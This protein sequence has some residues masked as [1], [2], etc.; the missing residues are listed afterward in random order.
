MYMENI[1]L[2]RLVT[3]FMLQHKSLMTL[4]LFVIIFTW[5]AEA[6]VLS[7]QYSNLVTS[8][9]QKV[10]VSNLF[11]IGENLK[12]QNVFGI[13]WL[14]LIIWVSLII[15]Y[16]IK[17][18]LE[19]KIFPIYMSHIRH[20]LVSSILK[21]NSS[22]YKDI[23]SGEYI[24]IINELTHVFLGMVEK[25]TSKFLPLFI[26]ILFIA[27]YYLYINIYIG[28]TFT[29]LSML[30][31][32]INY[33]QGMEYA[34]SCA[35]RDKSY[36][37]LNEHINDTFNNSLNIHLN[38][39]LKF[40]EKKGE[41]I[42]K[43]YD[44]EQEEEMN[45]RKNM[46]WKSNL[47]SVLCFIVMIILSYYL[48]VNKKLSLP[49][50]LTIAFIEI[51][52]VGTFIEFDS[53]S[54]QF[55]QRFGTII[56]TDKFLAQ[57]FNNKVETK[58]TCLQKN[59]SIYINKM[60]F[61][62]NSESPY[63]FKNMNLS[64]KSGERVGLIGR[65]GSGKTS[66]MKLLLGLNTQ[67]SGT[68]KIGGCDIKRVNTEMLRDSVIYI[69]QRTNLFNDTVLKNIQYGNDNLTKHKVLS[70]MKKYDLDII[71]SGL[72][73][74]I[75]AN[76]GV[77]GSLLSLGMQKITMILRGIFKNG[78]I[79]VFDEP[80]A[81]LDSKTKTKV[82]NII[83]GIPRDKTVIVVTHDKEILEHLDNVYNLVDLHEK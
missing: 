80:L 44:L 52:L 75:H 39:T 81:G 43:K 68:I 53:T 33:Y 82:I 72:E 36:F 83:N 22:N 76:V 13:L 65:S 64:I 57:I 47:L 45:V 30:R 51:K 74:G 28:G 23:K 29:V 78:D 58:K 24:T 34:K 50:L 15:F 54:L 19:Q 66:L 9:K 56:A 11:D 69:N 27:I 12:D 25:I 71:Y 61:K 55:F 70:Y 6:I 46:I 32:F 67:T 59:G 7:R 77:N 41:K 49:L 8:L 48:Y 18:H 21:S 2:K 35:M 79:I 40:E 60:Y 73:K 1:V 17:Y 4:Y 63:V 3:D 20:T 37:D 38:N 10:N 42:N 14:I 62:Y 31:I 5:P 16:R 26:G